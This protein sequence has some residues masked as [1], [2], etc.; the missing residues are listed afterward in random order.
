ML[1][2]AGKINNASEWG[3][4]YEKGDDIMILWTEGKGD[5]GLGIGCMISWQVLQ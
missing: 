5:I 2:L 1:G 3:W 4:G